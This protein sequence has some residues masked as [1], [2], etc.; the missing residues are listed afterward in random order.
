M[1]E[2]FARQ[3]QDLVPGLIL[4]GGFVFGLCLIALVAKVSIWL[5]T[6]GTSKL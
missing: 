6:W 2:A 5:W 4:F 1:T 3:W